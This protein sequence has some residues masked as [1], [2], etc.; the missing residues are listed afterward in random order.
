[1]THKALNGISQA[2]QL[3]LAI[4]RNSCLN[5]ILN[6]VSSILCLDMC[7]IQRSLTFDKKDARKGSNLVV[8]WLFEKYNWE[9]ILGLPSD[10]PAAILAEVVSLNDTVEAH[11]KAL[12]IFVVNGKCRNFL[13]CAEGPTGP[14]FSDL[15]AVVRRDFAKAVET[16]AIPCGGKCFGKYMPSSPLNVCP[17]L[18]CVI[19]LIWSRYD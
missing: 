17:F 10:I 7:S 8:G 18:R 1:M 3:H 19:R 6:L 5:M 16:G 12:D 15:E 9:A 11:V 2:R 14:I 13:L 4:Q